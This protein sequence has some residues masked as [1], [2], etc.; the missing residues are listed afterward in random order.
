MYT[1]PNDERELNEPKRKY[2]FL[3]NHFFFGMYIVQCTQYYGSTNLVHYHC[4]WS[5]HYELYSVNIIHTHTHT[6]THTS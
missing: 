3:Y 2:F 5:S 4:V 6:H 1:S